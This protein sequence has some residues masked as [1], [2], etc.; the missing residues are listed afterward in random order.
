MAALVAMLFA[1][2]PRRAAADTLKVVIDQARLLRLP[3]N[4]ATLVI[5][6]PLIADASMQ[7]GG[8]VV[9]TGK[10]YGETN[11]VALDH[12]GHVLLRKELR[13]QALTNT[14]VVYRGV[15]RET[16]RCTPQCEPQIM[17]GDSNQYFRDTTAQAVLHASQSKAAAQ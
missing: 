3:K 17:L 11:L 13:V 2:G 15:Q 8:M 12:D 6:N 16:Y 14:V 5:G 1:F 7:S 4:V 9:I 10:A